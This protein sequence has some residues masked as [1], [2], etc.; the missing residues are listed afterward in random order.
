ML[1]SQHSNIFVAIAVLAASIISCNPNQGPSSSDET[2]LPSTNETPPPVAPAPPPSE[3]VLTEV[4]PSTNLGFDSSGDY[5]DFC[6]VITLSGNG[7]SESAKVRIGDREV[8]P[9]SVSESEIKFSFYFNSSFGFSPLP[10]HGSLSITVENP[11]GEAVTKENAFFYFSSP[12]WTRD[13]RFPEWRVNDIAVSSGTPLLATSE[14]PVFFNETEGFVL[15]RSAEVDFCPYIE[16]SYSYDYCPTCLSMSPPLCF[17]TIDVEVLPGSDN[18]L[19]LL[20]GPWSGQRMIITSSGDFRNWSPLQTPSNGAPLSILATDSSYYILTSDGISLWTGREWGF[21]V[22]AS[23]DLKEVL[24]GDYSFRPVFPFEVYEGTDFVVFFVGTPRGLYRAV[25]YHDPVP[26]LGI[27][28][29]SIG[30]QDQC[31]L[32][33]TPYTCGPKITALAVDPNS[34][35]LYFSFIPEVG[36][37]AIRSGAVGKI[38]IGLNFQVLSPVPW[39]YNLEFADGYLLAIGWAPYAVE[40]DSIVYRISPSG[41][42]SH[43]YSPLKT[44]GLPRLPSIVRDEVTSIEFSG[45]RFY[46]FLPGRGCLFA[47]PGIPEDGV[48]SSC[49]GANGTLVGDVVNF[50]F[51]V[52]ENVFASTERGSFRFDDST[53][54]WEPS[55]ASGE[56]SLRQDLNFSSISQRGWPPANTPFCAIEIP[57]FGLLFVCDDDGVH[58]NVSGSDWHR[59]SSSALIVSLAYQSETRMLY[60]ASSSQGIFKMPIP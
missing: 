54:R 59:L 35:D 29:N 16:F 51:T 40:E 56:N 15:G 18:S 44:L 12:Y 25:L 30:P 3:L 17:Q 13:D 55:D 43:L 27:G 58:V 4:S 37:Y 26:H 7:F 31:Y 2:P 49:L 48:G 50:L 23:E 53:S 20:E 32:N 33:G 42:V 5:C 38:T 21:F 14:G 60:G 28:W 47:S 6:D 19:M 45:G 46:A 1:R 9:I 41:S 57:E 8:Q 22:P 11:D 36:S 52:D 24:G 39:I 10:P 34:G